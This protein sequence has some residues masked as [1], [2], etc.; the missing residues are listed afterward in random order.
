MTPPPLLDAPSSRHG[1][2]RLGATHLDQF[3]AEGGTCVLFCARDPTKHPETLDLAVILPEL[4]ARFGL[5][6]RAALVAP[7]AE[8][9]VQRRYGLRVWPAMVF[10]R[11]DSYLGTIERARLGRVLGRA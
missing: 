7:D 8:A 10:L 2:P 1:I 5:H 6:C 11:G 9:E 4:M 3:L